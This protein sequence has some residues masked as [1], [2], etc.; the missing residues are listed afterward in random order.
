M[1]PAL[2]GQT[3]HL[4]ARRRPPPVDHAAPGLPL[5]AGQALDGDAEGRLPRRG[6]GRGQEL[7]GEAQLGRG[8]ELQ[9]EAHDRRPEQGEARDAV[10]LADR[11]RPRRVAPQQVLERGVGR[12]AGDEGVEGR[13]QLSP[14]EALRVGVG[15]GRRRREDEADPVVA[16]PLGRGGKGDPVALPDVVQPEALDRRPVEPHLDRLH[17]DPAVGGGVEDRDPW[18]GVRPLEGHLGLPLRPEEGLR[19]T[20]RLA[21]EAVGE[22]RL[23]RGRPEAEHVG[24]GPGLGDRRARGEVV[25]DRSGPPRAPGPGQGQGEGRDEGEAAA[26]FTFVPG[27]TSASKEHRTAFPSI[28][29]ARTMPFDST[30]ISFAGLRFATRTTVF[31][32]RASGA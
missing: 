30:P 12:R 28:E 8:R 24:P 22:P 31:P 29:P 18:H 7:R 26:H 23:G 21:V 9:R 4:L 32:T 17:R 10:L 15:R 1:S 3:H 25:D 5:A 11:E 19:G 14:V 6:A 27:A 16:R 2:P 13:G 20:S